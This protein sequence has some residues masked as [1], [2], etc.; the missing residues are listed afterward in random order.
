M[1]VVSRC[2]LRVASIGWQQQGTLRLTVVCR[3]TYALAPTESPLS[4]E[5]EQPVERDQYLNDDSS[6]SLWAPSDLVPFKRR[7]DVVLVGHAFAPN[8]EPAR[9]VIARLLVGSVD[10]SI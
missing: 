5:Q 6:R 7:A 8:R 9:S 3:A 10:K 2:P 4:V 1:D